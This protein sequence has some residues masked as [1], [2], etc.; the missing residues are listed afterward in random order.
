MLTVGEILKKERERKGY[1]LAEIEKEIKVR[2]KF[3]QAVENNDWRQFSSRIYIVGIIK[4]YS[5]FL[6]LD[7]DKVIVYFSRDYEK[8]EE[9]KFKRKLP[10][11][12]LNP[13][14]KKIFFIVLG[15]IF[16]LFFIYFGY[17]LKVYFSPP[18]VTIISPKTNIVKKDDSIKIIGRTEKEAVITVLGERIYQNKDGVF[19]FNYPVKPGKNIVTIDVVGANGKKTVISREFVRQKIKN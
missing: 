7:S 5:R 13:E 12:Y 10:S 6:G 15:L 2:E 4:N 9:I 19:E 14:T 11:H 17:Q 1:F 3:L 18:K 16:T 8:K